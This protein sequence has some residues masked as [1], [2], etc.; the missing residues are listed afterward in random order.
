[1]WNSPFHSSAGYSTD[2]SL[3]IPNLD[4]LYQTTKKA[5]QER[6]DPTANIELLNV[7][8][9]HDRPYTLMTADTN[10]DWMS[11]QQSDIHKSR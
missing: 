9:F 10:N 3:Q 5:N 1:M 4:F 2:L 8:N 6:P 11:F 7:S